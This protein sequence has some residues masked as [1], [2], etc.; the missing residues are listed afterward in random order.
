VCDTDEMMA[1]EARNLGKKAI[2][3][4][5]NP[6]ITTGYGFQWKFGNE[7][8]LSLCKNTL[9]NDGSPKGLCSSEGDA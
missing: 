9:E 2:V 4:T 1:I 6:M 8:A 5:W 3:R 7:L